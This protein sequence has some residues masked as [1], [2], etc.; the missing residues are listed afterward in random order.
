MFERR[1]QPLLSRGAFFRRVLRHFLYSTLVLGISLGI[2]MT[3]YRFLGNMGWVDAFLNAS[4]ILTGMGPVDEMET[5]AAK[6]FAGFYALFSGVA[7]LSV[8]AV[9]FAPVA[10]RF[11]HLI[12][13]D[14]TDNS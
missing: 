6:L 14:D 5:A 8:V 12:H 11:L 9:L 2:G 4:M 3:G 1:N 10:H 13:L 7:F